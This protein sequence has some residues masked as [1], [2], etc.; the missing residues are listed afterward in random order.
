MNNLK[1]KGIIELKI[2]KDNNV[3]KKYVYENLITRD[4]LSYI[5]KLIG[6]NNPPINK[7][8]LGDGIKT[9]S[10]EDKQLENLITL[11]NIIS[12][13]YSNPN[14]VTFLS[15]IPENSVQNMVGYR[16]AGLI[17]RNDNGKLT[18]ITRTVFDEI[19]YQKPDNSLSISYSIILA[20]GS[21]YIE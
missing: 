12:K 5:A 3:E 18:L 20:E 9:P 16:E 11:G 8:G 15:V 21:G 4:G 13:D 17:F 1:L 10:I 19:V 7:I 2:M 6:S 14:T